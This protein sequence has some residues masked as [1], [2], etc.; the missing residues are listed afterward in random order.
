M[1]GIRETSR[2]LY[3]AGP[4]GS[5]DDAPEWAGIVLSLY[6][7]HRYDLQWQLVERSWIDHTTL[8]LEPVGFEEEEQPSWRP[9]DF[10]TLVIQYRQICF[11]WII[12]FYPDVKPGN[13][14]TIG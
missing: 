14:F 11:S 2:R 9:E 5:R 10:F 6:T 12:V 1:S 7:F 13:I 8:R 4:R 3:H